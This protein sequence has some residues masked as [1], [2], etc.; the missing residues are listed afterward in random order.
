MLTRR[1]RAQLAELLDARGTAEQ[2][3]RD[4]LEGPRPTL[5]PDSRYW[6]LEADLKTR[7][8]ALDAYLDDLRAAHG[9]SVTVV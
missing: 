6:E 5:E 2:A 1:E 8:S 9:Q 7:S 3:L 4:Y